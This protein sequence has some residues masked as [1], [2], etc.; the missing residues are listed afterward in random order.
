MI[1]LDKNGISNYVKLIFDREFIV[2]DIGFM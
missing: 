2:S 1:L